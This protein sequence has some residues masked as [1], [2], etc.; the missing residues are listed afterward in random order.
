VR[1]AQVNGYIAI[2]VIAD[3]DIMPAKKQSVYQAAGVPII[4]AI[5][6]V[7][8]PNEEKKKD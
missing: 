3:D 2:S 1:G 6:P 4:F 5:K 8:K 7:D